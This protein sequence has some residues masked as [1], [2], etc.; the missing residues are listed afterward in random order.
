MIA[1]KG[2]PLEIKSSIRSETSKTTAID[3]KTA[4]MKK[5]VPRNFLMIYQSSF[6]SIELQTI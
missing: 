5:K 3:I 4:I 1:D 6:F 2:A